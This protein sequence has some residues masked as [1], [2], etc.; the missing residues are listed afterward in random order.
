MDMDTG[1]IIFILSENSKIRKKNNFVRKNDRRNISFDEFKNENTVINTD[2][3][4][5]TK[6]GIDTLSC[7]KDGS[8][9][10]KVKLDKS[11]TS[12]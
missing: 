7:S 11:T 6:T 12:K 4:S 1:E 3:I 2:Q 10:G 8:C 5:S 9:D